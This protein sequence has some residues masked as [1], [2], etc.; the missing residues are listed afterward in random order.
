MAGKEARQDG[1][2]ICLRAE[3]RQE[4]T[5]VLE[6]GRSDLPAPEPLPDA[7]EALQCLKEG[8]RAYDEIECLDGSKITEVHSI[9]YR[10]MSN[11]EF[12]A[13]LDRVMD[14]VVEKLIPNITHADL[15][16]EL[17]EITGLRAA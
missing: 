12:Q 16:R 10:A 5:F 7:G 11:D 1:Q 4:A 6:P 17:E 14:V 9:A 8:R 13:F 15:R 3:E 2:G